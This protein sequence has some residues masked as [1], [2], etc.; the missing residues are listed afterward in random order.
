MD[1]R[2]R[3]VA[4]GVSDHVRSRTHAHTHAHT[5]M[6]THMSTPHTHTHTPTHTCTHTH[7]HARP[8][9][10]THTHTHTHSRAHVHALRAHPCHTHFPTDGALRGIPGG[11]LSKFY[12]LICNYLARLGRQ[13]YD[14]LPQNTQN[15]KTHI[16]PERFL[17][18]PIAEATER[19][20]SPRND[21]KYIYDKDGKK[22]GIKVR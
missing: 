16:Y 7:A 11:Q 4:G 5:H 1:G 19:V 20:G 14:S 6:H 17:T 10:H 9:A 18:G 21:E 12:K 3:V 22:V 15:G 2:P 8:P 13:E